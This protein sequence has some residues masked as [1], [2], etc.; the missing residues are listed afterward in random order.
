MP[1]PALP[2]A[3]RPPVSEPITG[4][5]GLFELR[6]NTHR[7]QVRFFYFFQPGKRIVF[8][9]AAFKDRKKLPAEVFKRADRVRR[10]I[11]AGSEVVHAFR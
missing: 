3:K 11:E 9:G 1:S 6:A 10:M 4:F 2:A 8:V 7:K 5:H